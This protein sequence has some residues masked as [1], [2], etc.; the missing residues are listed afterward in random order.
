MISSDVMFGDLNSREDLHLTFT[1]AEKNPPEVREEYVEIPGRYPID[2]SEY[3]SGFP[4]FQNREMIIEFEYIGRN[5]EIN[6]QQV[7]AAIHGRRLRIQFANDPDWYYMGRCK[8]EYQVNASTL[9]YVITIVADPYKRLVDEIPV[10]FDDAGDIFNPTEFPSCP[11]IRV[12]GTGDGTITIGNQIITLTG[13][14]EY[15]DIDCL[16]MDCYKGV[17]NCNDKIKLNKFPK[18]QP[19]TTGVAFD[20]DV[21]GLEITGRWWTL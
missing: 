11:L 19:G 16:A 7:Y 8:V 13:I 20:G 5:W 9:H 2:L 12:L 10:E 21:E 18:L 14:D 1:H 6:R 15:V 4:Q 17:I 3:G